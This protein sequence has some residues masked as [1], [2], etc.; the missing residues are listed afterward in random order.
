MS[1]RTPMT[2]KGKQLFEAFKLAIEAERKAQVEY[3]KMAALAEDPQVRG[4]FERFQREEAEHE[5]G[6]L[7]L[8]QDLKARFI[9]E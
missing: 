5:E 9:P 6:L 1:T 3:G 2:H 8:Y 7:Q 4:A